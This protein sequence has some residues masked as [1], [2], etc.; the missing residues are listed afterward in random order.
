MCVCLCLCVCVCARAHAFWLSNSWFA[1]YC[2]RA[3]TEV[4]LIWSRWCNW[5]CFQHYWPRACSKASTSN[6]LFQ[7]FWPCVEHYWSRATSKASAL[8]DVPSII[9]II[10]SPTLRC[11]LVLCLPA[12]PFISFTPSS[13]SLSLASSDEG[14]QSAR[15]TAGEQGG[16]SKACVSSQKNIFHVENAAQGKNKRLDDTNLTTSGLK[17]M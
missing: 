6:A 11:S 7:H 12:P 10:M 13:R 8:N 14:L 4:Q 2:F 16:N 5:R 1:D 3:G 15:E 17:K 9:D